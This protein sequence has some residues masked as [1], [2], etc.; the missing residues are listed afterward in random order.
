M[1]TILIALVTLTVLGAGV[2]ATPSAEDGTTCAE[3]APPLCPIGQ[4]PWW[5][6]YH[7][8]CGGGWSCVALWA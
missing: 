7:G 1:K 2:I 8:S 4:I 5:E 3:V 6:P